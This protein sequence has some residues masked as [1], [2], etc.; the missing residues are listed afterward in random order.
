MA[1][2]LTIPAVAAGAHAVANLVFRGGAFVASFRQSRGT[3]PPPEGPS[4]PD[5]TRIVIADDDRLF[6]EMLQSALS[7]HDE[8]DVVGIAR[9]G[10]EAIEL[11]ERLNPDIVLMDWNMPRVDGIEAT[12]TLRELEEPPAV[13]LISGTDA[14]GEVEAASA[15][16]VGY[17]R[18]A[19][20]VAELTGLIAAL[21]TTSIQPG[22]Y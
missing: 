16:A 11:A 7:L 6:A 18:K 21:G 15:G 20:D 19:R 3:M 1:D 22:L 2:W 4:P 12:R 14:E 10:A 9:D 13:V 8:L 17:L 5:R